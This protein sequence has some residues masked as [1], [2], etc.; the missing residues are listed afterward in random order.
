[1]NH[2][3]FLC[4]NENATLLMLALDNLPS[5]IQGEY[6][7]APK[8]DGGPYTDAEVT[9]TVH[10]QCYSF[11]AEIKRI[12]R[13]ESL[14]ALLG[15]ARSDNLLVCNRLTTHLADFCTENAINFIDEAGNARV[16]FNGLNLWIEGKNLTENHL[17]IPQPAKPGLGFMKLLFALLVQEDVL[18]LPFRT[19]A[20]MANIS[21]GMVSKG[22][23]Y[24]EA[25]KLVSMGST[26]RILDKEAL[27]QI[28][29]EHYRTVLRPKLGGLKLVA[30]DDWRDIPLTSKD[31]WGGEAAADE[32]TRY[33]QP[34]E[35]QLFTFEPLQKK[36]ALLK[37]KPDASGRLW[38]VPAFWGKALDI[39]INAKALLAVAEL[40]AS[41]DS[42]NKEVAERINEQYLQLKTLPEPRV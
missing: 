35:L 36:L 13:K 40:L 12:H 23:K 28:W 42:R 8:P 10:G 20:E 31:C 30:P 1:M 7:F 5:H 19:I 39:N 9:L 18:H 29:I 24:L 14:S 4:V 32:L 16:S 37:A 33:L 15:A 41:R 38:V 2:E 21:L 26:R 34:Y 3:R 22:F 17:A 6:T 25:E 11:S 27:Y